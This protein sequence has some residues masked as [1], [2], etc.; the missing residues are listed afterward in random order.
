MQVWN[1]QFKCGNLWLE[2]HLS[3]FRQHALSEGS[4]TL[5]MTVEETE[6]AHFPLPSLKVSAECI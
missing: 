6:D 5:S 3:G 1:A 4:Y 2:Y